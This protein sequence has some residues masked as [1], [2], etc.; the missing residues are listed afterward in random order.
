MSDDPMRVIRCEWS[1]V[2]KCVLWPKHVFEGSCAQEVEV[3]D[4]GLGNLVVMQA[5]DKTLGRHLRDF[6]CGPPLLSKNT[7]WF[8]DLV[9]RVASSELP[10]RRVALSSTVYSKNA[11]SAQA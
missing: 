1:H 11:S 9:D 4:M 10:R 5:F 3:E 2:I 8:L 6:F 7:A